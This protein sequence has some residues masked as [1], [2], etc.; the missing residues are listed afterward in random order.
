M[1]FA[2]PII[3]A[4]CSQNVFDPGRY[5]HGC[6]VA[7]KLVHCSPFLDD[8]L[9]DIDKFRRASHTKNI[10]DK[11]FLSNEDLGMFA[12]SVNGWYFSFNGVSGDRFVA[13]PNI[14]SRGG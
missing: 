14:K 9:K 13:T 2:L 4:K 10:E 12:A 8:I 11:Q 1:G 7:G 3:N 5:L 6:A